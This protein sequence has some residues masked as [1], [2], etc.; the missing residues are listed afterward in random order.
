MTRSHRWQAALG[1]LG[2]FLVTVWPPL[3][4]AWSASSGSLGD[5]AA[6]WVL[7]IGVACA[8]LI[9]GAASLALARGLE[10]AERSPDRSTA[11]AWGGYVLGMGVYVV[12]L[13]VMPFLVHL[14]FFAEE[15]Q[16]LADRF[17]LTAVLWVGSHLVAAGAGILA[18]AAL[19]RTRRPATARPPVRS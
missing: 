19:V 11:D 14:L 16:P 13:T 17:W 10:V 8:A 1:G 15:G 18:G 3:L 6:G 12:L 5:V 9:G 7:L 4:I 2:A